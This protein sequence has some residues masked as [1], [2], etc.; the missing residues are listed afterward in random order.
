MGP[1]LLPY[2]F[3]QG[4]SLGAPRPDSD[5]G[6]LAKSK[7]S[8]VRVTA[9]L[10]LE[11]KG[12]TERNSLTRTSFFAD[13]P[14]VDGNLSCGGIEAGEAVSDQVCVGLQWRRRPGEVRFRFGS[15]R[16]G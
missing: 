11:I 2:R 13:D 16:L 4:S 15:R 14:A 5:G 12:L 8:Q 10:A 7:W 9:V 3:N 6:L 1:N